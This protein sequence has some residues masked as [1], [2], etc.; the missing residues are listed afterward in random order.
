MAGLGTFDIK[1][2]P[3]IMVLIVQEGGLTKHA[4]SSFSQIRL[5]KL[6]P[7]TTF[8]DPAKSPLPHAPHWL[9][10]AGLSRRHLMLIVSSATLYLADEPCPTTTMPLWQARPGE[11]SHRQALSSWPRLIMSCMIFPRV[12]SVLL[13]KANLDSPF[14][15]KPVDAALLHCPVLV[16][17]KLHIKIP[18]HV[19]RASVS[20]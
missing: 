17:F 2:A 10:A 18:R 13:S 19:A 3:T 9:L 12:I 6:I 4:P 1:T 15:V 20:S 8:A 5:I 11:F 14:W 7:R 16:I